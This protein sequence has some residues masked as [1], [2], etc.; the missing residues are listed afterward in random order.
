MAECI[1]GNGEPD[2]GSDV[3][4]VGRYR[5]APAAMDLSAAPGVKISASMM[6]DLST[7]ESVRAMFRH[8]R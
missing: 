1:L 8:V 2:G 6:V 7:R 3:D 4:A 5:L